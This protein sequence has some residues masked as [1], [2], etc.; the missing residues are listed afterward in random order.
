MA[1]DDA[2]GSEHGPD[3]TAAAADLREQVRADERLVP[4]LLPIGH[5]LLTAVKRA[6]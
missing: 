3:D 4:L 5:G 1:F 2:L 6:D